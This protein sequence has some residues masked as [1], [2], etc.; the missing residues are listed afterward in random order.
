VIN[1]DLKLSHL[2]EAGVDE[3]LK[4]LESIYGPLVGSKGLHHTYLGMDLSFEGRKFQVSMI[5]CFQEIVDQ[6]P[7]VIDKPP[8]SPAAIHLFDE[9]NEPE[10]LGEEQAKMFHHTIIM[11]SNLC[12]AQ[13][14]NSAVECNLKG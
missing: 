14:I 13:F 9:S 5:P 3:E 6:F 4:W 2:L 1:N 10:F 8:S 7:E 11:R 12:P